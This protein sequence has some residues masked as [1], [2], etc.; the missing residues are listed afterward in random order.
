MFYG[1]YVDD[2]L[3]VLKPED[4]NPDALNNF[5]RNLKFTLDTFNDVIPHILDNEIHS[6]WL[7]TDC[8]PT[9]TGQYTHYVSF[10]PWC[11]KTAW[12]TNIIQHAT[13]VCD[14]TKIQAILNRIKKLIAWNGFPKWIG[15][16]HSLLRN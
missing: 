3:G 4:L 6:D 12:I 13:V 1:C 5:G 15:R 8:K 9:N 16:E 10:S 7:G 2:G 11:F 14:E